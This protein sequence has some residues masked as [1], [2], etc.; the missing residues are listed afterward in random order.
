MHVNRKAM[1][2][3]L[4]LGFTTAIVLGRPTPARA[5]CFVDNYA[6]TWTPTPLTVM[7]FG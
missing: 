6:V 2:A 4:L 7:G 5:G 3:S 1:L